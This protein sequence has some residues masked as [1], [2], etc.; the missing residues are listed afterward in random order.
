ISE[1]RPASPSPRASTSVTV[2]PRASVAVPSV[3]P[4]GPR[5]PT[6]AP[7]STGSLPA[8]WS[9]PVGSGPV[10]LGPFGPPTVGS[11]GL[12][13]SLGLSLMG[14]AFQRWPGSGS[15]PERA[16]SARAPRG[17]GS[18]VEE[19]DVLGVLLDEAAS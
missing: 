16:D 3:V 11:S 19:A 7:G 14:K 12:V 17:N 15:V 13:G 1:F 2:R 9:A 5:W 4:S 10:P 8:S 6:G 18:D